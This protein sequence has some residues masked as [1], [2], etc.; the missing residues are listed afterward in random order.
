MCTPTVTPR[1]C[2]RVG[3]VTLRVMT[4]PFCSRLD[5]DF[6]EERLLHRALLD[7]DLDFRPI[8]RVQLDGAIEGVEHQ[9]R[10]AG[11]LEGLGFASGQTLGLRF[12]SQPA[13]AVV[14]TNTQAVTVSLM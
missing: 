1:N 13:N 11:D 5:L 6:V 14:A 12:T 3:P 9:L 10:L 4:S 7:F 8:P 2:V